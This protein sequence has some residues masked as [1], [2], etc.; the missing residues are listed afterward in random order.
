[1]QLHVVCLTP[2][3]RNA[4]IID[5]EISLLTLCSFYFIALVLLTRFMMFFLVAVLIRSDFSRGDEGWKA[6]EDGESYPLRFD[7]VNQYIA[8]R[9][10]G[11]VNSPNPAYFSA[12]SKCLLLESLTL[13]L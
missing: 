5:Y 4:D 2:N 10:E 13:K 8:V 9:A 6:Y 12:P 1:M 11:D 7:G 3:R